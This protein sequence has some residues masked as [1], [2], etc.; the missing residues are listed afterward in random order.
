MASENMESNRFFHHTVSLQI[1]EF[2][3]TDFASQMN[4]ISENIYLDGY[5]CV[6][7]MGATPTFVENLYLSFGQIN[8]GQA[9]YNGLLWGIKSVQRVN[10]PFYNGLCGFFNGYAYLCFSDSYRT[11]CHRR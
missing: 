3:D 5:S 11:S 1:W 9:W 2:N 10:I 6:F 7:S 8:I 4:R